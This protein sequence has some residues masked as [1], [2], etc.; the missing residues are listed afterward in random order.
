MKIK[1]MLVFF[2]IIIEFITSACNLF[3]S[4]REAQ[5]V[6][7]TLIEIPL[8]G[9]ITKKKAE[10]SGMTWMGD[11]L[12]I[13]P[14]YP[15]EFGEP[16]ILF[17]IPKQAILDYL[18]GKT[19]KP[20]TPKTIKLIMPKLK[21]LIQDYEG[22]EAIGFHN[23]DVYFTIESGKG[24]HMMGYLIS[25]ILSID[26]KEIQ[27]DASRLAEIPPT[28]QLDNRTYEA[29]VIDQGRIYT[30]FEVN[31]AG[32]NPNPAAHIF[33][34]NLNALGTVPFPSLEYRITDAALGTDG[35]IWIINQASQKDSDILHQNSESLNHVERLVK[36]NL[37]ITGFTLT[38]TPSIQIEFGQE[39]RNWEG[40]ALLDGRGFLL[41]TDKSPDTILGFISLP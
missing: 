20:I 16:G 17:T 13:L 9:P 22:F 34:L 33:D 25:G 10:L 30:F 2:V 35:G 7:Q 29:L 28:I 21:D 8:E 6:P 37:D 4:K 32:I 39:P 36:L 38:S 27:I 24:N 41:V 15:D 12:V 14:Q 26:N 19:D 11:T 18:D 5:P 23:Q 40:L 31:G 3:T 1:Y